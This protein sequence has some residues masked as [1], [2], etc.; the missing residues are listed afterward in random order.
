MR[1]GPDGTDNFASEPGSVYGHL[2]GAAHRLSLAVLDRVAELRQRYLSCVPA[3]PPLRTPGADQSSARGAP[4]RR[5]H[6]RTRGRPVRVTVYGI[7]CPT[8]LE[9]LLLD[10]STSGVG[11]WSPSAPLVGS[12]LYL[13]RADA[14]DG[15]LGSL[16]EVRYCRS[17]EGGWV[18]GC[19]LLRKPPLMSGLAGE[20]ATSA[21]G[22]ENRPSKVGDTRADPVSEARSVVHHPGPGCDPDRPGSPG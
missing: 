17:A 3:G 21:P 4:E 15:A 18:L 9:T 20:P 12:L 8:V 22:F 14:P 6:P 16:V 19:Q 13:L 11:L 7:D 10:E 5:S 1:P 2:L